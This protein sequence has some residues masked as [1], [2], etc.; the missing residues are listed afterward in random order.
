MAS[1]DFATACPK[2]AE[3]Y[4]L[5][6]AAGTLVGLALCNEGEGKSASAWAEFLLVAREAKKSGRRPRAA[7]ARARGEARATLVSNFDRGR[8]RCPCGPRLRSGARRRRR[9]PGINLA[10]NRLQ[11]Q[12]PTE[13]LDVEDDRLFTNSLGTSRV[14]AADLKR[15]VEAS[16]Q[17]LPPKQRLVMELRLYHQM[18]FEEIAAVAGISTDAAK[19]NFHHGLKRLRADAPEE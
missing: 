2:F 16:I 6:P 5:D 7:R 12:L 8:R 1:N 10:L 4:R 13:P 3:S 17:K 15:R 18:S 9:C 11:R 14:V 19:M